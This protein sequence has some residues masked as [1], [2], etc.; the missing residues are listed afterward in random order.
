MIILKSARDIEA[1]RR[2]G[3]LTAETLAMLAGH[4][5][6]GVSTGELDQAA[7]D[8]I[9]RHNGRPVFKGYHGFP[10]SICASVNEVVV[11]GIPGLRK[12]ENGDIISI[13]VGVE[14]NGFCGDSAYTFPVGDVHPDTLRLL[15]VTKQS[16]TE[17]ISRARAELRLGDIS[18]A[19]QTVA[20]RA[21]FSVVRDYVGHGIGREMHEDPQVPNYGREGRGLR[22]SAGMVLAIEPMINQGDFH[23]KTLADGWTVVTLDGKPSAHFEHTVAITENGP[24]I[25][26]CTDSEV[27]G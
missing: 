21:G 10:A 18:H 24:E 16:L 26:T 1:M 20:E 12:L 15:A 9:R 2:A 27:I 4:I 17:G 14:I 25:L 7:E 13:D 23:V 22:L 5:R 11:H 19:V 6:V 3:R 8:F